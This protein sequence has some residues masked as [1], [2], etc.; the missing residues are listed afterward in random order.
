MGT[1]FPGLQ[2]AGWMEDAGEEPAPPVLP[3]PQGSDGAAEDQTPA[4]RGANQAGLADATPPV[5]NVRP[6]LFTGAVCANCTSGRDL[7]ESD[8]FYIARRCSN[9]DP[10][11]R[12]KR[13]RRTPQ[14]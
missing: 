2:R 7:F 13:G 14:A 4:K 5:E 8:H 1:R 3:A 12:G 11:P 10:R 6:V 9:C